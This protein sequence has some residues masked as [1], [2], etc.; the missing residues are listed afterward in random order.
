MKLIFPEINHVFDFESDS[1]VW[2]IIIESPSLLFRMLT[3]LNDELSGNDGNIVVSE[4]NDI[5]DISKNVELITQFIPFDINKRPLVNKLIE[6]LSQNAIDDIYYQDTAD[7]LE[8]IEQYLMNLSF[9]AN[10]DIS[11]DKITIDA[12]IRSVKP[13]FTDDFTSLPEKLLNY[14]ELVRAYLKNKLFVLVNLRSFVGDAEMQAFIDSVIE[15]RFEVLLLESSQKSA[16]N[17]VKTYIVDD[18]LCEIS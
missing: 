13:T 5:L 7:L 16:L 18:D 3:T 17:H 1:Y 15:R 9:S 11:F 8:H 4:D 14:F 6:T 2:T 12:I 10:G